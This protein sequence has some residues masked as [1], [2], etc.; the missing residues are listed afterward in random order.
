M[1]DKI[2]HIRSLTPGSVPTTSTLG[3]GEIAIN[4]PD[5][6]AFL[7]QSGSTDTIQSFVTTNS[8]TTGSVTISGSVTITGSLIVTDGITGSLFGT[9]SYAIS[10][11][12]V[13]SASYAVT[14]SYSDSTI[15]ASYA[16]SASYATSASY[17]LSSSYSVSSSYASIAN[18]ANTAGTAS[19]ADRTTQIDVYVK[20][21]S[22]AQIN[23]GKVVRINGA[24]GDNPLIVTASYENDNNSANTL[25]ITTQNIANDSFGYVITEGI[26]LGVDTEAFTAGQLIYLGPT[27]SITGSAPLAPLH[28]VRLGEVLRVQQNNGS[29]Y[30]RI[31][32]GYELGELHNV[33]DNSTTSSY[34]DL[35]IK[36]GSVWTNSRTLSGSYVLSG[37]LTTNDGVSVQTLTASVV[38]ASSFTGSLFGTASWATQASTA[39]FLPVGTYNITSSWANQS[40]TA[41]Y[42]TASNVYGPFGSDSVIS[43]SYALTASYAMNGGGGGS[44]AGFPFTGS[45]VI[46]GS[47]IVTGSATF[48]DSIVI[49]ATLVTSSL[50]N[51]GV[52][53]TTISTQATGSYRAMFAKYT[54][55]NAGNSRAGEFMAAWNA[56]NI[57]FTDT[58]TTDIGNTSAVVLTGSLT[59]TDVQLSTGVGAGWT[60][61]TQTT[62]I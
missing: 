52:G 38:S 53:N 58:S 7:R 25:G 50:V 15:S 49:D 4:V 48:T 18:Y 33:L 44:G 10:A 54:I 59:T 46:T 55:F 34:G 36:S 27:G 20:N 32:N 51:T 30:V 39:S 61:K 40:V 23:K 26:L 56:G 2:I 6:K 60:V 47:L 62:Y 24:T 42:V 21:V 8:T 57:Q 14:S 9:A 5:G 19:Y 12:S 22:G 45:A 16:L 29:I 1:P 13:I 37:S 28:A 35:L 41:S 31:D 43:S 3:V 11:S 17:A